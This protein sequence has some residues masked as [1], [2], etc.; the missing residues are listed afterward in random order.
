MNDHWVSGLPL[1]GV[2]STGV[3]ELIFYSGQEEDQSMQK[4]MRTELRPAI[5][6]SGPDEQP[7]V[8]QLHHK[9]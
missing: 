9:N 1:P 6:H 5:L 7:D 4:I 8:H 3:G 2:K